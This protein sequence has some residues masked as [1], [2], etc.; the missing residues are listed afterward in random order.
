LTPR[1]FLREEGP[2]NSRRCTTALNQK[3]K[4]VLDLVDVAEVP[5]ADIQP[6]AELERSDAQREAKDDAERRLIKKLLTEEEQKELAV[7]NPSRP[8]A[9]RVAPP[10]LMRRPLGRAAS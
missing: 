8:T 3:Q 4:S 1:R 9:R 2:A 5:Q 10:A 6:K 7:P